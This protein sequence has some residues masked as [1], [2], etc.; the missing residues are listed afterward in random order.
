MSRELVQTGGIFL[1]P[2]GDEMVTPILDDGVARVYCDTMVEVLQ[3][4]SKKRDRAGHKMLGGSVGP[5]HVPPCRSCFDA[6][7]DI[8]VPPWIG[9]MTE[10]LRARSFFQI[11]EKLSTLGH[12][13]NFLKIQ[14]LI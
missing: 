1:T 4:S 11:E 8:V 14:K 13:M 7:K 5:L 2:N 6:T 3:N 10:I 9:S 12:I